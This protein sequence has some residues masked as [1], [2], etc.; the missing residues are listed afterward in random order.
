MKV[1]LNNLYNNLVKIKPKNR[2]RYNYKGFR[3]SKEESVELEYFNIF[4]YYNMYKY[5]YYDIFEY[6]SRR[7][8]GARQRSLIAICINYLLT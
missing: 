1:N 3:V 4:E 8:I 6:Y 5:M 7:T 2:F